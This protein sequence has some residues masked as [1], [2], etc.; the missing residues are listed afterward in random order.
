[1]NET[2][3]AR[4]LTENLREQIR[5][6]YATLKSN[7]PGFVV[8]RPQSQM[9]GAA[10]RA[11]A[12]SGGVAII[13][14]GTGVG[15]SLGYLTAGVPVAVATGRKLV[16]ST[17][18]VA[19]QSQLYDRDLPAFLKATGISATTALLK[20]R[21]R[22]FCPYKAD[23]TEIAT[24]ELFDDIGPLYDS[25]LSKSD[26][27][28]IAQLGSAFGSER[29]NGDL[30]SPPLPV[31]PSVRS[32]VTTN[33]A[34]CLGRKCPYISQ[35]PAL[36]A[37][38]TAQDAQIVVVNHALLLAALSMD[39]EGQEQLLGAP[40][41]MLLVVDEGHHLPSVA[42]QTGAASVAIGSAIKRLVKLPPVIGRVFN[43]LESKSLGGFEA[44]DVGEMVTA[45][46]SDLKA[47][48]ASIERA[49]TP[50]PGDREPTWRAAHGQLPEAWMHLC[51]S[52]KDVAADL[53][54]LLAGA[55][56]A[57]GKTTKVSDAD[58]GKMTTA[59]GLFEEAISMQL[60]LWNTWAGEQSSDAPPTAKWL[61]LSKDGDVVCHCSP[62]SASKLLQTLLWN[63]VDATVVTS[64]TISAGGDFST[65]LAE[66]GVPA[67]AESVALP[68][69]F[70]LQNQAKLIVPKMRCQPQDKQ[71][72]TREVAD[73]LIKNLQTDAGNLVLFTS[74][75]RMKEVFDLLPERITAGIL[76]QG[77]EPLQQLVQ[78]HVA[79]IDKGL[80]ST[81]FG[82]NSLGEGVD[83]RGAYCS[84]VYITSLTFPVPT[85][86]IL[87][88]LSEWYESQR[89]NSFAKLSI[90]HAIRVL[91]QF[92]GRLI[93]SADDT[94]SIHILDPRLLTKNY[95][96][97][98]LNALPP[99]GRQ[100][101]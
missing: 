31:P 54:K 65:I 3:P 38:K 40:E 32:H 69:P 83:L 37:R 18:T 39:G 30:D 46:S 88:T 66:M 13:E 58:R 78:R 77:Q 92:A 23:T 89:M 79:R 45:Y 14:A 96:K 8:R 17:G 68:S 47:L 98:I 56:A 100:L 61:T 16:L 34:G 44:S 20:G 48:K 74:K 6:T 67:E 64:A 9:I 73:Y 63:Q 52:L 15:K 35:C 62:S 72:H 91:T 10:S 27:S 53:G 1:M 86:P 11:L 81:L 55:S 60:L 43:V 4:A 50:Q 76:V 75:A 59:V 99:F 7:T 5:S 84:S 97:T 42:V 95:G 51:H 49:W 90:P 26:Q 101:G 25:P 24:D 28:V 21:G 22:Y 57:L 41:K 33:A 71:G 93:R 36:R 80:G 87:A 85:D 94:G 70:D 19:L 29:W 12:T 82:M 2:S